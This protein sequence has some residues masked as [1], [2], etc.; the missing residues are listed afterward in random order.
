MPQKKDRVIAYIDGF[1]L[2]FGLVE[3]GYINSKWLNILSLIKSYLTSNQELTGVKYFTS[4]IT[5]NPAKQK[6]QLIYLDAIETTGV[7]I[8]YGLYKSIDI[9]CRNCGHLWSVSNEKMTDV[10]IA[11]HMLIDA[12]SDKFDTAILVSGDSDLVPPIKAVHSNFPGKTISVFFPP[13]R[14][15]NSVAAAAK[16][17]LIIGRKRLYANQLP[18]EIRKSDGYILKRPK[19]W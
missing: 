10:N 7:Q 8:I 13:N 14:H 18:E 3:G 16:G 11:T 2:Y 4:R 17:Y 19:D 12:L 6:R 5:N 1:K 9:E 15:N